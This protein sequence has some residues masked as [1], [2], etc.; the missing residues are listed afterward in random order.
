MKILFHTPTATL[1]AYPRSDD[2]HV[3]GLASEFQ[4]FDL[5]Q[6]DQPAYNNTTHYLQ[7]LENIDVQRR[8]VT[9][10]WDIIAYPTEPPCPPVVPA[11][12][13]LHVLIDAGLYPLI[14]STI[15]GIA[16]AAERLKAQETF[17]RAATIERQHPLVLLVAQAAGKTSDEI[18]A[19]FRQA[20][21]A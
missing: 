3:I 15:N 9:R 18:D 17:R 2:E 14:T 8:K 7:P 11:L 1:R 12:N 13:L 4:V 21:Q 10:G 5:V 19:Y 20:A 16:D 6:E